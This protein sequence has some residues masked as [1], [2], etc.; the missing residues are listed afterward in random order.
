LTNGRDEVVVIQ[1][2]YARFRVVVFYHHHMMVK[3]TIRNDYPLTQAGT[4]NKKKENE[5]TV[6]L[7]RKKY[8]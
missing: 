1:T 3:L 6:D 7:T 5:P 8:E 4:R 2:R